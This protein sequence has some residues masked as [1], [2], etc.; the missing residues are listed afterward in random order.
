MVAV[1]LTVRVRPPM[2]AEA[3]TVTVPDTPVATLPRTLMVRRSRATV[4]R[5][6]TSRGLLFAGAGA[7]ADVGGAVGTLAGA[8]DTSGAGR[9][10][11]HVAAWFV[12]TLPAASCSATL[13]L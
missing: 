11:D 13:A 7:G 12:S 4:G 1:R 2:R 3:V 6:R 5:A 9:V 10:I 8:G